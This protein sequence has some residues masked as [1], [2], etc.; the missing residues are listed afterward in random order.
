MKSKIKDNLL[1]VKLTTMSKSILKLAVLTVL[2]TVLNCKNETQ[3]V[4]FDY[5]YTETENALNCTDVDTKLIHEA[6]LSFEDDIMKTYNTRSSDLRVAY[7]NFFRA[8]Q[9]KG[10][11]YQE[12]V[13]PHSMEVFNAL[14]NQ[15]QLWNADNTLNYKADIFTC[16][17]DNMKDKGLATTYKSLISVNS[18]RADIFGAPLLNKVKTAN[19][20]RYLAAFIA[21]DLY[22]SKL[23][24]VDPTQ[25]TEKKIQEKTT[26]RT[27]P[28][29]PLIK[30]K[31]AT[32]KTDDH[33]G[34]NH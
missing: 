31:P 5:K 14:K 25:V 18:M 23:F 4:D 33:A 12:V 30:Q 20:D 10:V 11:K 17:G 6:L 3:T 21:L 32:E 19:T 34:H 22:Y 28:G 16:I 9:R 29:K 1:K 2:L 8:T 27:E 7:T 26:Y 24:D 15:S 13:T